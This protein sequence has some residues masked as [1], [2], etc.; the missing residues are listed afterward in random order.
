[1]PDS[2]NRTPDWLE[3]ELSRE[4]APTRAPDSLHFRRKPDPAP[5]HNGWILA[6]VFAVV[7]FAT[8]A[9]TVWKTG[10]P[11]TSRPLVEVNAETMNAE[12]V[13]AERSRISL[14]VPS[15]QSCMLCHR[16]A[17]LLITP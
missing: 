17:E 3:R 2:V 8:V 12:T 6:P 4:L 16:G 7:F 10:T 11:T 1:V 9:G 15:H 14:A 5:R 13:T